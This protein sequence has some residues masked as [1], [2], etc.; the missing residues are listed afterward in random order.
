MS[1]DDI[2]ARPF[3]TLP[4]L[5][6]LHAG[7]RPHHPA[8]VQDERTLDYAALDALMDRI[9][10][11][12]QR[13]GLQPGNAIAICAAASVEYAAVFLGGLRAGI[14]VAPLAPSS[15]AASVATMAADAGAKLLFLD[16]AVAQ[17][18]E[19]VRERIAARR[20]G[21]DAANDSFAAWLAP[22]LT[23]G[24]AIYQ[25]LPRPYYGLVAPDPG[26]CTAKFVG[27]TA[28]PRGFFLLR[29]C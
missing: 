12:L 17:A 1:L 27:C 16:A 10:A 23:A 21:L 5:I 14:A 15:T 28:G 18:L 13:D 29:P 8:L 25:S 22:V 20:I 2:L 4:E 7:H 26:S 6:R 3:G 24:W 19:P 9:A 11:A